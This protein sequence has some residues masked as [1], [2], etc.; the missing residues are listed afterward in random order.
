MVLYL[1][2][3]CL[4]PILLLSYLLIDSFHAATR[5]FFQVQISSR[6]SPALHPPVTYT[7]SWGSS[8]IPHCSSLLAELASCERC[9]KCQIFTLPDSLAARA[10][11][12]APILT[13]WTWGE[14]FWR[15]LRNMFLLNR[16]EANERNSLFLAFGFCVLKPWLLDPNF[17]I[18][19]MEGSWSE[20][21]T[22]AFL[23]LS[24]AGHFIT[25]EG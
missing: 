13:N 17:H 23:K 1:P 18:V 8:A 4:Q 25:W 5:V 2:L 12:W 9:Q 19:I 3:I 22:D 20:P 7:I 14:D 24:T 10:S 21:I 15:F 16:K 11:E 6:D